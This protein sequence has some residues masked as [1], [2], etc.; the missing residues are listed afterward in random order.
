[1][2]TQVRLSALSK[3]LLK[4]YLCYIADKRWGPDKKTGFY[5]K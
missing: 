3:K 5:K 2:N 1:M 4:K